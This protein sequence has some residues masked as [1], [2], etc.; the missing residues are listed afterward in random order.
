MLVESADI[1]VGHGLS[2]DCI[3]VSH[4]LQNF[5][6][7]INTQCGDEYIQEKSPLRYFHGAIKR[8]NKREDENETQKRKSHRGLGKVSRSRRN[9]A[10]QSDTRLSWMALHKI[11]ALYRDLKHQD[12]IQAFLA[13]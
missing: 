2:L 7:S 4:K 13:I 9:R 11:D 10:T 3:G 8:V 5:V 6:K 1:E 12:T